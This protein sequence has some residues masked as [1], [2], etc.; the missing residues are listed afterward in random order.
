MQITAGFENNEDDFLLRIIHKTMLMVGRIDKNIPRAHMNSAAFEPH[1]SLTA[2]YNIPFMI[3]SMKMT[4]DRCAGGDADKINEIYAL[5]AGDPFKSTKGI[6]SAHAIMTARLRS[7]QIPRHVQDWMCIFLVHVIN[8]VKF[9]NR[10]FALNIALPLESRKSKL[11]QSQMNSY[12]KIVF[13][14]DDRW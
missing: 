13:G 7:H 4:P 12:V 5:V 6:Y 10:Q 8:P 9:L 2:Y 1:F 11:V 14:G 3:V